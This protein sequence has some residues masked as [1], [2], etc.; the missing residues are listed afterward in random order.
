LN[1]RRL[2]LLAACCGLAGWLASCGGESIVEIVGPGLQPGLDLD[3]RFVRE[4]P[5]T[6]D[7]QIFAVRIEPSG[8]AWVAGSK[9]LILH[10]DGSTWRREEAGTDATVA[11][12][13]RAADGTLLA[14]GAGGTALRDREGH[15][16]V[17]ST[18]TASALRAVAAADDLV[19][20]VGN[21]GT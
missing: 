14:V 2:G 8:E 7:S 1:L 18:P 16:M 9:G 13:T 19:W 21:S 11:A 5:I 10:Y 4:L 17:E 12:M 3:E 6:G 20:A 15:W